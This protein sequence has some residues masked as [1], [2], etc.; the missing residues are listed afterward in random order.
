M[1]PDKKW[2]VEIDI[3]KAAAIVLIVLSHLHY[4][5]FSPDWLT[6]FDPYLGVFGVGMFIFASGYTLYLNNHDIRT[7]RDVM[8]FYKKRVA[9]IIPLYWIAILAFVVLFGYLHFYAMDQP[10]P[11]YSLKGIAIN[12]LGLQAILGHEVVTMWFIGVILLYY[13]L[14]PII[15]YFSKRPR[16]I[17]LVSLLLIPPM[18]CLR[19][20]FSTVHFYLYLYYLVFVGG[21][22]SAGTDLF[23][24]KRYER[25]L[26][27]VPIVLILS[28]L[29]EARLF[30]GGTVEIIGFSLGNLLSTMAYATVRDALVISLSIVSF[31]FARVIIP[32]P[33]SKWMGL[34][35]MLAVGSYATF[36]FHE[37]FFSIVKTILLYISAGSLLSDLYMIIVA[38]PAVFAVGY[39]IQRSYGMA[40]K[41]VMSAESRLWGIPRKS[42]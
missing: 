7:V 20:A 21:I 22:L 9:R 29:A 26:A 31:Q 15:I 14:Y 28:L 10:N 37:V 34:I 2:S 11:D 27:A 39:V 19:L 25:C 30:N 3:M 41:L 8:A 16:D 40:E 36:L 5:L 33:G 13:I 17:L 4:Y 32:S 23:N 35:S 24:D 38:L 1:Q 42:V 6:A 12:V 18:L